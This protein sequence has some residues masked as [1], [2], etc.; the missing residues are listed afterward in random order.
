MDQLVSLLARM[1]IGSLATFLAIMLW[2]KTRDTA[3]LLII[4][5]VLIQ[6]SRIIYQTLELLGIVSPVGI[7]VLGVELVNL[8]LDIL[9]LIAYTLGILV[10][11]L[12]KRNFP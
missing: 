7:L 4:L 1:I 12:R 11:V 6:F 3:W 2:S 10:M 8:L 9:P 5:G